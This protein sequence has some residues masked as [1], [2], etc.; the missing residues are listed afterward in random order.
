MR[1]FVGAAV[2][3]RARLLQQAAVRPLMSFSAGLPSIQ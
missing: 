1:S 2:A 3:H